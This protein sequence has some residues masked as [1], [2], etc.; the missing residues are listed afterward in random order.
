MGVVLNHAAGWGYVA[1]FWWADRYAPVVAPNFGAMGS[2]AYFALRGIEQLITASVPAFLFVSGFFV[3]FASGRQSRPAWGWAWTR[4]YWLV[5]PYLIWSVLTLG[6]D[7]ALGQTYSAGEYLRRLLVGGATPAFYFVPLLCQLYLLSPWIVPLAR[8]HGR[9]LLIGTAILQVFLH[10]ARYAI[11]LNVDLPGREAWSFLLSSWFFP[12][13]LL[14]FAW[15]TITGFHFEKVKLM[16]VRARW[17]W[18]IGAALLLPV[19]VLE[20]ETILRASG[21]QWIGST[22]TLLDTVF[23]LLCLLAFLGFEVSRV[24]GYRALSDLGGRAFGVYVAHS[25]V[26]TYLS[27]VIYHAAP[28]A[29]ASQVLYQ[30]LLIAAGLGLPL[31]LMALVRNS[32]ARRAYGYLFG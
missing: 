16:L 31:V 26:L 7:A 6:G 2:P 27:K 22:D 13:N 30:P 12:G 21:Q 29:L 32:P 4:I 14:W 5:I 28:W 23:S 11:L 18:L 10:A 17:L 24:P 8:D 3:A 1:M 15:G 20:W 19:G 25:V 9:A